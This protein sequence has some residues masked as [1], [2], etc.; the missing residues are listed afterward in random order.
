MSTSVPMKGPTT[1]QTRCRPISTGSCNSLP[2]SP[3]IPCPIFTSS[4]SGDIA[5]CCLAYSRAN[6]LQIH[7]SNLIDC[8]A[9][10]NS[11][12]YGRADHEIEAEVH[13]FLI[14]AFSWPWPSK[15][16]AKFIA[17]L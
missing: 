16:R 1:R 4:D 13:N 5:A 9:E 15:A 8:I 14:Q 3:M 12:Q 6:S 10:L 11:H 7:G 17:K 2:S